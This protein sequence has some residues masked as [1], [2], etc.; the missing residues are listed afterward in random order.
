[1]KNT[2]IFSVLDNSNAKSVL[3]FVIKSTRNYGLRYH[4]WSEHDASVLADILA[5]MDED[6]YLV[7]DDICA[8]SVAWLLRQ[9]ESKFGLVLPF[10]WGTWSDIYF[11]NWH[12]L[13]TNYVFSEV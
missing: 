6:I 12:E 8:E 1:M 2:T 11:K 5:R 3:D 13:S 7:H 10:V 9:F 4:N